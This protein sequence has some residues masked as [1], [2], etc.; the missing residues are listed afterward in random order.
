MSG[1]KGLSGRK[2]M[3][4]E[5]KRLRIKDKAWD[6][7]EKYLNDEEIPLKDRVEVAKSIILKDMP[8]ELSGKDGVPLI[9]PDIIFEA[10][11]DIDAKGNLPENA[12]A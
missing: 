4:D 10:R 11:K 5:E 12:E 1:V 2:S 9:P 8:I 3:R 6:I 7:T